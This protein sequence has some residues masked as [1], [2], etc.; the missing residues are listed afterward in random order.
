MI[1]RKKHLKKEWGMNNS[2]DDDNGKKK[3]PGMFWLS[4]WLFA[5]FYIFLPPP[6]QTINIYRLTCPDVLAVGDTCPTAPTPAKSTYRVFIEQ[7][8]VVSRTLLKTYDDCAV[9]DRLNW[10]CRTPQTTIT[11][12]NGKE[13]FLPRQEGYTSTQLY[14]EA[15]KALQNEALR[16][17]QVPIWTWYYHYIN[18]WIQSFKK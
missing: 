12:R 14:A 10:E 1:R 11:V 3:P 7:Q 4:L 6:I 13:L 9:Y 5:L 18:N 8:Y 17:P 16:N 15:S 2:Y